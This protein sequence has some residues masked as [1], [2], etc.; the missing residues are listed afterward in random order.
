MSKSRKPQA[1][2]PEPAP[3]VG[4]RQSNLP[5]PREPSVRQ[6]PAEHELPPDGYPPEEQQYDEHGQPYP[7]EEQPHEQA[8][9]DDDQQPYDEH[10]QPYY[11]EHGQPY[12]DEHGQPYDPNAYPPDYATAPMQQ[13]PGPYPQQMMHPQMPHLPH[14]QLLQLQAHPPGVPIP[15]PPSSHGGPYR[16]PTAPIEPPMPAF[17]GFPDAKPPRPIIGSALA[18]YGVLLWSFVVAGQFATSWITGTPMSQG[19]A[20]FLV[21]VATGAAWG[22]ALQ[23]SRNALPS[24]TMGR[25]IW[26]GIGIG[27]LAFLL[28]LVTLIVATI[29]GQSTHGHDFLIGFFLVAVSLAAMVMG[30]R[31]TLP[32]R[33]ER[34]HRMKFAI[35]SM[36][37]VGAILTFVAGA[38]LATNG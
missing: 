28:F 30:P 38:E 22:F 21:I 15:A 25:F 32:K 14:P 33:P 12:Y 4:E 16:I 18:V 5:E 26:R 8:Y 10:G 13:M 17:Q 35:I 23:R 6:L 2:P 9:A 1:P 27:A 31:L 24:A 37:V 36:W 29:F 11:D 34:T 19:T 3:E 20:A 7:A